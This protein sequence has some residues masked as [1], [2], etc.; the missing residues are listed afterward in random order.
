MSLPSRLSL[1]YAAFFAVGG[2]MMPFWPLWLAARDL[3]PTE[4]SIVMTAA[5]WIR[6][7]TTPAIANWVDRTGQRAMAL[8]GLSW[9]CAIAFSLHTL[10]YAFLPILLVGAL[11]AMLRG[12]LLPLGDNIVMLLSAQHR[13]DYGRLRVWGSVSF[14]A[15]TLL[16]GWV[17]RDRPADL[18]LSAVILLLVVAALA[19]HALPPPE[20]PPARMR[21]APV[22][23]VLSSGTVWLFLL[24]NSATAGSHAMFYALGSVHWRAQG[25]DEFDIGLLWGVGVAAEISVFIWGRRLVERLGPAWLLMIGGIVGVPRWGVT[26]GSDDF[27]LLCLM[28]SLHAAT[29]GI[30]HL[31]A[32]FFVAR[33]MPPEVS[34]SG[35][36]VL[37]TAS[38]IGLGLAT[39]ACGPL[40]ARFAGDAYW[41]MAGLAALAALAAVALQQQWRG[42]TLKI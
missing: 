25:L 7:A 16:G 19:A 24:S 14:L 32:M 35:Q 13:L 20:A 12:P 21:R 27:L 23:R 28:Q 8:I 2:V 39:L 38:G 15:A 3:T 37:S 26:A 9:A 17:L 31:G 29:F 5:V 42:G 6:V 10:A 41:A 33:A 18:I 1:F 40:Y 22:L 4:I 30:A 11:H 36:G 34:A